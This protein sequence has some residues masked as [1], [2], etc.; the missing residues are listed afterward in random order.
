MLNS[1]LDVAETDPRFH[2]QMVYA[3]VM[4]VLETFERALGRP[5][6]WRG[7]RRLRV[8][9]HAFVGQNAYFDEDFSPCCSGTSRPPMTTLDRTCPD[10]SVFTALSHDII[11][12]ETTHAVLNRLRTALFDADEPRRARLP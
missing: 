10:R 1:G 3:V 4:R 8:Y 2:Q 5:F 11:A 6:R 9:P 12:H 7:K